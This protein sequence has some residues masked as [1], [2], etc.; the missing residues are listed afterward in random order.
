NAFELRQLEQYL[1]AEALDSKER[2][3]QEY[4]EQPLGTFIRK[5]IGLDQDAILEHF[6]K[7][8]NEANLSAKQIKFVD[9]VVRYFSKN[10]YLEP[11]SLTEPPFTELDDSGVIGMFEDNRALQ[12][13]DLVKGVNSNADIGA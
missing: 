6:A 8:I 7:F 5:I 4:G 13:I 10:G 9:T 3:L 11:S 2:L 12:L 1:I